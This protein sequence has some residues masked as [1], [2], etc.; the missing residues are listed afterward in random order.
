MFDL[1]ESHF[2]DEPTENVISF[3]T[4]AIDFDLVQPT[5]I[6][7]WI[8]KVVAQE[9]AKIKELTYIFCDDA[10]LHQIN[11]EYLQHDTFTDIITFPYAS[12]PLLHADLFISVE[13]VQENA[14][15]LNLPFQQELLRVMIHGV[16]HLCGYADKT[17]AEQQLMRHKE[18]EK[19]LLAK[20][21]TLSF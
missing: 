17:E 9:K 21:M 12:P 16:L 15:Q 7:K 14:R 11:V 8:R 5:L 10:Y 18:E 2:P 3:F 6:K 19:L 4:E 13:R 1:N 20:K